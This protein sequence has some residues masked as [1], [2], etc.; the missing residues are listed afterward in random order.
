MVVNMTIKILKNR[1]KKK[2]QTQKKSFQGIFLKSIHI[3]RDHNT[4][5]YFY[6]LTP[7]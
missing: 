2:N 1:I 5:I 7:P 4:D 6:F 3:T